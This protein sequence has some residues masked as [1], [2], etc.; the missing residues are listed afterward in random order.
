[1]KNFT[2]LFFLFIL[3]A[4]GKSPLLNL[5]TKEISGN[6]GLETQRI[7]KSNGI[8]LKITWIS[9]INSIDKGQAV[10]VA[11]KDGT[12]IDLPE[13]YSIYLWMPDMNHGSSPITIDQLSTG[14]YKL[15]DIYFIMDGYWQLRTLLKS[16]DHAI[17][18]IFFEYNL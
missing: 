15:T 18:E 4:C 10:L 5:K 6:L 14:I 16:G 11:S 1:M 13:P 17:E 3:S 2:I 8:K 7:F 9:N 12:L